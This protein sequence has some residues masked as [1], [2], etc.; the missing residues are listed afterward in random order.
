M[1]RGTFRRWLSLAGHRSHVEHHKPK[2]RCRSSGLFVR[3]CLSRG[4]GRRTTPHHKDRHLARRRFHDHHAGRSATRPHRSRRVQWSGG[5]APRETIPSTRH[6]TRP[7]CDS[8]HHRH[9]PPTRARMCLKL[10]QARFHSAHELVQSVKNGACQSHG[11]R[12]PQTHHHI[13]LHHPCWWLCPG[14]VAYRQEI[15]PH[16]WNH[17]L[18]QVNHGPGNCD[19]IRQCKP[20]RL[21]TTPPYHASG[22]QPTRPHT[23]RSFQT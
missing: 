9:P 6:N 5:Q 7:H 16:T 15:L 23:L 2:G 21:R 12:L 10:I 18:Q 4:V 20:Y 8:S 22:Q 17:L 14:H 11:R 3:A 19:A 1:I 13:S